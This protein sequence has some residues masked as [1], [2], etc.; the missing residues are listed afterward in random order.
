VETTYTRNCTVG[1]QAEFV[2]AANGNSG[3]HYDREDFVAPE[4]RNEYYRDRTGEW[5]RDRRT[6]QDRRSEKAQDGDQ[7]R[8]ARGRRKADLIDVDREHKEMID[9]ALEDFASGEEGDE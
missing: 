6:L 5:Q 4:Q 3:L 2:N 7:E 8:R 1:R 9:E